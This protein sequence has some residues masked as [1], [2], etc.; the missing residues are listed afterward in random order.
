M[1]LEML[2]RRAWVFAY[3]VK[4]SYKKP[5]PERPDVNPDVEPDGACADPDPDAGGVVVVPEPDEEVVPEPDEE[6]VVEPPDVPDLLDEPPVDVVP[7]VEPLP[8]LEVVPEPDEEGVVEPPDEP[9]DPLVDVVPVV[10]VVPVEVV[11]DGG[12]GFGAEST[13]T[14]LVPF[15]VPAVAVIVAKPGRRPHTRPCCST[16]AI[17]VSLDDQV[18][19]T[20]VSPDKTCPELFLIVVASRIVSPVIT[21]V[22]CGK[23]A[24]DAG[25]EKKYPDAVRLDGSTPD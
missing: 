22:D 3:P 9:D 23:T 6:V 1:L 7:V 4:S 8:V 2:L 25:G 24:T 14:V 12:G 18:A 13:F 20:A 11:P 17:V 10:E 19:L 5:F 15:R 21:E 16:V